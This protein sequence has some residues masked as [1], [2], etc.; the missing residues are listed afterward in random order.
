MKI[1]DGTAILLAMSTAVILAGSRASAYELSTHARITYKA[2]EG[3]ALGKE[4]SMTKDLG[5]D[6]FIT[7]SPDNPFGFA[8]YDISGSV[9]SRSKTSF[10]K[11]YMDESNNPNPAIPPTATDVSL[12]GWLMRGAIREDD[13]ASAFGIWVAKNPQNDQDPPQSF[14]RVMNHF[15]DPYLNRPLTLSSAAASAFSQATGETDFKRA[16]SW[17]LGADDAF[18]ATP[19]P[20]PARRNHFTVFDAREAMYRALIGKKQDG[21]NADPSISDNNPTGEKV[22]KKYWATTFR[23]LGDVLHLNQDMAQLQHMRSDPH[24]AKPPAFVHQ[25]DGRTNA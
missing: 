20:D 8:Y 17:A 25:S 15:F 9:T 5:I 10:E 16:P 21:T 24:S 23:A 1:S 6:S 13:Y 22:R 7:S 12:P 2:Y 19:V 3:S 18:A 4:Q 14:W 11:I